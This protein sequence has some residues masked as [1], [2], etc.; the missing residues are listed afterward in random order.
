MGTKASDDR[1]HCASSGLDW[2]CY[3]V[4]DGVVVAL[5][6]TPFA[7]KNRKGRKLRK[8]VQMG[9][10][11]QFKPYLRKVLRDLEAKHGPDTRARFRRMM[12]V[13]GVDVD[14]LDPPAQEIAYPLDYEDDLYGSP[15]GDFLDL[16]DGDNAGIR[17]LAE[18]FE[19]LRPGAFD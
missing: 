9:L 13:D 18:Y 11:E 15:Y 3:T 17:G 8:I 7:E 6:L 12:A 5:R 4:V 14:A 2:G 1:K 10:L 19:V 16:P